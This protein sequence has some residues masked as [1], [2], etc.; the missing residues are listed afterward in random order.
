E[1]AETQALRA[2]IRLPRARRRSRG[3]NDRRTRCAR[4]GEDQRDRVRCR[5]RGRWPLR[6]DF[7]G[8]ARRRRQGK[9]SDRRP[10]ARKRLGRSLT[11]LKG[12]VL[13]VAVTEALLLSDGNGHS[14]TNLRYS[15]ER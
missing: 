6:R 8:Q 1:E 11:S 7:L 2:Q 13:S 3:R 5:Q 12:D 15:R 4:E 14:E 10:I 9:Q